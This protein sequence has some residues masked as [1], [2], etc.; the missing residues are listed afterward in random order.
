[1]IDYNIHYRRE[2]DR[3]VGTVHEL[4]GVTWTA[5]IGGDVCH[6]ARE[7]IM[8]TLDDP[9]TP[10]SLTAW[11]LPAVSDTP[12]AGPVDGTPDNRVIKVTRMALRRPDIDGSLIEVSPETPFR[13]KQLVRD[14]DGQEPTT[15]QPSEVTFTAPLAVFAQM[16][17]EDVTI[18]APTARVMAQLAPSDSR[19]VYPATVWTKGGPW[20]AGTE[21]VGA[22]GTGDTPRAAVEALRQAIA[23]HTDARSVADV[24]VVAVVGT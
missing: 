2:N 11:E 15:L 7:A 17:G 6:A 23:L 19:I 1:V 12:T 5:R 10:F 20:H 24:W 18:C 21:R 9:T 14:G 8:P 4:P 22:L 16:T 13:L 3:Y